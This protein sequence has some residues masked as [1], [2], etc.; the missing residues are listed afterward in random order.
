MPHAKKIVAMHLNEHL[1]VQ[2]LKLFYCG[3][4]GV[5]AEHL[6]KSIADLGVTV[7]IYPARGIDGELKA[8][9]H[10]TEVLIARSA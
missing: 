8:K 6:F 9:T 7:K 10:V 4:P 5:D 2:L 3:D 1:L